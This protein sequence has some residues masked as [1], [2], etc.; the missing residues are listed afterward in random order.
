[1]TTSA[2]QLP[3][4]ERA[5]SALLCQVGALV[6]G[7][8]LSHIVETMRPLS[9]SPFEGMPPFVSGLSVIR[10]QPVPVVDLGR[11]LGD[12]KGARP[13][14]WVLTR[15]EGRQVALAVEQV[16][17]VRS[18][19]ASALQALPSLLGEASAEFVSRVGALDE[20]LL[21]MLES[22]RVL[23]EPMRSGFLLGGGEA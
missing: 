15:A 16:I 22:S 19:P 5:E 23:P 10:G 8:P 11:L 6:C 17:G 3:A 18:L 21:V 14:R 2:S 7:L 12:E 4:A 20:R 9:L 13:E 1:M